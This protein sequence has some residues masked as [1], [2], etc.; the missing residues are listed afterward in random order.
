MNCVGPG[1][2]RSQNKYLY[3]YIVK[4]YDEDNTG[5]SAKIKQTD[6]IVNL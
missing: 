3:E 4:L 5:M 6:K 2:D 1:I